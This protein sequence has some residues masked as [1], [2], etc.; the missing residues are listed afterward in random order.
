VR[1]SSWQTTARTSP[2]S[3]PRRS[4]GFA[5]IFTTSTSGL[6][7]EFR[8]L[9]SKRTRRSLAHRL[10]RR[11]QTVQVAICRELFELNC[12]FHR[13]AVAQARNDPEA[14][15]LRRAKALRGA[16]DP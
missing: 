9:R 5:G 8:G 2:A 3:A 16:L 4:S 10:A 14:R 1:S 11:E 6:E 7:P 13:I 12:A 15:S